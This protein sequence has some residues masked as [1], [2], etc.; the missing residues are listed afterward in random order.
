MFFY[1]HTCIALAATQC[2]RKDPLSFSR[3]KQE[4]RPRRARMSA[5][6]CFLLRVP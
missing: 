3:H 4:T 1:R 2:R 5:A 6:L